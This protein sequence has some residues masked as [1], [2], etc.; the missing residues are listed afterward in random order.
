M[1]EPDLKLHLALDELQGPKLYDESP[2]RRNALHHGVRIVEDEGFGPCLELTGAPDSYVE[3]P[4]LSDVLGAARTIMCWVK[5]P[6]VDRPAALL[7][8]ESSIGTRFS[9]SLQ[10]TSAGEL[11]L[12]TGDSSAFSESSMSYRLADPRIRQITSTW[13]HLALVMAPSPQGGY[14]LNGRPISEYQATAQGSASTSALPPGASPPAPV[15]GPPSTLGRSFPGRLAQFRVYSRALTAEEIHWNM[16]GDRPVQ[17]RYR[18]THPIDFSLENRDADPVL[19]MD[20]HP[21]GQTMFLRVNN[22]TSGEIHLA[23]LPDPMPSEGNCHFELAFRPGTLEQSS[24]AAIALAAPNS[25]WKIA[26]RS[27]S[28]PDDRDSLYFLCTQPGLLAGGGLTL[29]LGHVLPE[30]RYGTRTTLVDLRYR[31][32]KSGAG[33]T[34]SGSVQQNLDL[35]NHQGRR[36]IPLHVGF[37]G[38]NTVLNNADQPTPLRLRVTNVLFAN[39]LYDD[40]V[41]ASGSGLLRFGDKSEFLLSLDERPGT[42]WALNAPD[43]I[44]DIVVRYAKGSVAP[45]S[46]TATQFGG[47]QGKPWQWAIPLKDLSLAPEEHLEIQ[48]E[49]VRA[50]GADGHSNLY[51]D[52]RDI[53]GYWNGRF[54]AVIEKAPLVHRG[55]KVGIGVSEPKAELEV[56]GTIRADALVLTHSAVVQPLRLKEAW[57]EDFGQTPKYFKDP[58]GMVHL[59]GQCLFRFPLGTNA[60]QRKQYL[61]KYLDVFDLPADCLPALQPLVAKFPARVQF[62]GG[63][64]TAQ[65]WHPLY[66]SV[67]GRYAYVMTESVP[68]NLMAPVIGVRVFLDGI[69][70]LAK[71]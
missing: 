65:S 31:N 47:T 3:L 24:I 1:S 43:K 8:L 62:F 55:G 33:E 69:S 45:T 26:G 32:L 20:G 14:Y 23:P 63:D 71:S 50:A 16:E 59:T 39:D 46:P 67:S 68:E 70:Y 36:N 9:F 37:A 29:E 25:P 58:F 18:I 2:V 42:D 51:L 56:K 22:V 13:F 10:R 54:T 60:Q 52:Y 4:A 38:G 61:E 6:A 49:N 5:L 53:P 19:Y 15:A 34:I 17:Y 35:V 21:E 7:D 40:S 57:D 30:S 66:L 28:G 44:R 41:R 64:A 27:W 11:L 48:L 12:S